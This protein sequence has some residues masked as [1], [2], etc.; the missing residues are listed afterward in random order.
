MSLPTLPTELIL[1]IAEQLTSAADINALARTNQR[2]Y[3]ILDR[4]LYRF[5]EKSDR[6]TKSVSWAAREDRI[7]T[8]EKALAYGVSPRTTGLCDDN[9]LR[10]AVQADRRPM[11]ELLVRYGA[12]KHNGEFVRDSEVGGMVCL[13]A[14]LGHEYMVRLFLDNGYDTAVISDRITRCTPLMNAVIDGHE[15]IITLLL[16]RGADVHAQDAWGCTAIFGAAVSGDVLILRQ[17]LDRGADPHHVNRFGRRTPLVYAARHGNR[18]CFDI[19]LSL[20]A[21]PEQLKRALYAAAGRGH[22]G[23]VKTL[24]GHGTGVDQEALRQASLTGRRAVVELLLENG[25]RAD[26]AALHAAI[27]GESYDVVKLLLDN[28]AKADDGAL[29]EASRRSSCKVVTLLLE[30]GAKADDY[31]LYEASCAGRGEIAQLLLMNGAVPDQQSLYQSATRGHRSVVKLPRYHRDDTG[32]QGHAGEAHFSQGRPGGYYEVVKLMLD[33]GTEPDTKN[34]NGVTASMVAARKGQLDILELLIERGADVDV[35]DTNGRTM[36]MNAAL[37]QYTLATDDLVWLLLRSGADVKAKD[38]DGHTAQC[39]A[40][41]YGEWEMLNVM[42]ARRP[43]VPLEI[44]GNKF[45]IGMGVDIDEVDERGQTALSLA[46]RY[47]EL[48]VLKILLAHGANPNHVDKSG[49]T[50]FMLANAGEECGRNRKM[51]RGRYVKAV[52]GI[53]RSYERRTGKAVNF[54]TLC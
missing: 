42:L 23:I 16:E 18:G 20:G 54:D 51:H 45:L 8:A 44:K 41:L 32:E 36:L 11:A 1:I 26:Q 38:K 15:S 37:P 12:F 49:K 43:D 13:A 46:A 39:W 34:A 52:A 14:S 24:L 5:D 4:F 35:R 17:L 3:V 29:Q 31:A 53:L 50:V 10:Y 22:Y 27:K 21:E 33:N 6:S 47:K 19:L 30:S 48:K 40:F 9:P 2:F 7:E 28:G 25:T